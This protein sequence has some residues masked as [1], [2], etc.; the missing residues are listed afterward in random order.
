MNIID[1]QV[2]YKNHIIDYPKNKQRIID[3]ACSS[4]SYIIDYAHR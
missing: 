3:F 1:Y 4:K 2:P